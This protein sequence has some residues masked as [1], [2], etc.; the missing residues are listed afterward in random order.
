MGIKFNEEYDLFVSTG[1]DDEWEHVGKVKITI[2]ER[3]SSFVI[4]A[5]HLFYAFRFWN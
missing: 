1:E 4:K 5:K 2:K 3:I